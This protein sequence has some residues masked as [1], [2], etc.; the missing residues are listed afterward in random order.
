[1]LPL[2]CNDAVAILFM[3]DLSRKSTLVRMLGLGRVLILLLIGLDFIKELDQG[4]VSSG[5][6]V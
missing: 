1:M 5:T 2:V 4:V 6:R 3:F